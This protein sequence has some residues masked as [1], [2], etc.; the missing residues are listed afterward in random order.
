MA[1]TYEFITKQTAENITSMQITNCFSA[2]Y[3]I[4][5][6][7]VNVIEFS[8]GGDLNIRFMTSGGPDSGANYNAGVS[9]QRSYGAF[10]DNVRDGATSMG[11]IG[12][13]NLLKGGA[14]TIRV[15]EPFDSSKW[16]YAMWQNTGNSTSGPPVRKGIGALEVDSSIVGIELIGDTAGLNVAA[17][18]FGVRT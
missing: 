17:S 15:F 12:Y 18:V 11:S 4:Y 3:D 6:I 8:S 13:D 5:E 16:T 14:T 9:L 7:H 1:S 10:A 2:T